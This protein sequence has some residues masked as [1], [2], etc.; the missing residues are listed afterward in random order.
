VSQELLIAVGPGELRAALFDAGRATALRIE[1]SIGGSLV[2]C[3]FLG[4]VVEVLSSMAAAFVDIGAGAPA[5]LRE[6]D[7]ADLA[8]PEARG[9]GIAAWLHQGQ[10]VLVQVRKDPQAGKGA[11]LTARIELRDG[12]SSLAPTRPGVDLGGVPAHLLERWAAIRGRAA[13]MEAPAPLEP[14]EPPLDRVLAGFAEAAPDSI[15]IDD[16][17][18]YAEAR[19][20]VRRRS[21]QLESA[22]AFAADLHRPVSAAV[23]LA[24]ARRVS[25]AGGGRLTF[26]RAE[27]ATLIDVDAGAALGGLR[28]SAAEAALAVNLA[29]ADEA[30]RQI[31]LRNIGGAIV[32]DFVGTSRPQHRARVR[33]ALETALAGDPADVRVLGWTRLGHF[34]LTRT[35]RSAA[36][37]DLVLEERPGG[38]FVRTPR[39]VALEA[40]AE[41]ARQAR[42]APGR[43]PGLRVH[44]AVAEELRGPAMAALREL[45]GQLHR[46]VS[47]AEDPTID[48]EAFDIALA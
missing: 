14:P 31:R 46:A 24:L 6:R 40:L 2:G 28:R 9:R 35:R 18:A 13:D 27:A 32:I 45:E 23:E 15:R 37:A 17:A 43:V 25:L 16:R 34:E 38:A 8:P 39:T 42:H 22:L 29:A 30:A 4:R 3:V 21:P 1:R 11:G 26:D 7:A 36:I 12:A 5:L 20:W 48:R 44:P 47:I 19:A 41:A 10:A 33:A